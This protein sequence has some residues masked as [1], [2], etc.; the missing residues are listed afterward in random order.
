MPHRRSVLLR[1]ARIDRRQVLKGLAGALA[2]SRVSANAL[3]SAEAGARGSSAAAKLDVLVLGAGLSGLYAAMLLEEAGAKVR[4]LEGRERVGGR[5]YTRFELP[6]H[7]EVGGNTM[8]GGYGRTIDMARRTG[9]E[10]V[11]YAGRLA[12]T[13]APALALNGEVLS[14][15]AWA[16]HPRNRQPAESRAVLPAQYVARLIA[17]NNPLATPDEWLAPHSARHDVPLHEVLRRLGLDEAAIELGFNTNVPYGTSAHDLSALLYFWV[18][19]WNRSQ[20]AAAP[21]AL[22]VKGGNQR[23]PLAMAGALESEVLLGREVI[24]VHAGAS[25][26]TVRCRSGERFAARALVCSLPFSVLRH[27][28]FDPVLGGV[29]SQAVKTLPYMLNTLVFFVPRRPFWEHDGI[30]PS[31]WTDGPAGWITAQ[32]FGTRDDE[33]TGIVANQRGWAAAYVDRLGPEQAQPLVL[34]EI[35]RLR[36]AAKGQLEP[37]G[38]HSWAQ[39]RFA[40]GDWAVFAPGQVRAFAQGMSSPHGRVHF[41]GEHTAIG[42]RGM[43]GAM[44]SAERVTLEVLD[45]LGGST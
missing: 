23:L 16:R 29:Q 1:Q 24:A 41:C 39:D 37:V 15:E 45:V 33:V 25:G 6:G 13:P 36:P 8:A 14:P 5:L 17:A 21:V 34:S 31:M 12:S 19:A 35:E 20:S 30:S 7:P 27:V 9:L 22:A 18:D 32:R 2:V 28:A 43:E 10:L 11:N 42:N 26:V 4:V 3:T 40:A 44:E 38:F